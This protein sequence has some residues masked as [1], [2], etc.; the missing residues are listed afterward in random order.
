MNYLVLGKILVSSVRESDPVWERD[1]LGRVRG[2]VGEKAFPSPYEPIKGADRGP[3]AVSCSD[4]EADPGRLAS[5]ALCSSASRRKVS[6]RLRNGGLA[7]PPPKRLEPG[8]I[9]G[10]MVPAAVSRLVEVSLESISVPAG[11]AAAPDTPGPPG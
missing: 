8:L 10:S 9:G 11:P 5:T 7:W 6:S 3:R 1:L 4:I 2:L